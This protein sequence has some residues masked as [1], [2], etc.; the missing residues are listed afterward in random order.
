L[1]ERRKAGKIRTAAPQARKLGTASLG[2]GSLGAK[3]LGASR[4]SL[5]TGLGLIDIHR[6]QIM[7]AAM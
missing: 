4:P 1:L 3:S 7:A 2:A 6:S 5:S